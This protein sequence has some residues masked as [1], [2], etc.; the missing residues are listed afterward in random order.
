M[1]PTQERLFELFSYDPAT[2][3]FTRKVT[4]S[5]QPP[6]TIVG[7]PHGHRYLGVSVD[8]K[9]YYC[10]RLAW[11]YMTGSFPPHE[12]DHIN[13]NGEDNRW[14]NLRVADRQQNLMNRKHKLPRSGVKG[15]HRFWN[16]SAWYAQVGYKGKTYNLGTFR[17]LEEAAEAVKQ[18]RERL[19]GEFC[20]NDTL[21]SQ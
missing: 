3:S 1:A 2:G 16:D 19:H 7:H 13:G 5:N 12:I 15:V 17:C 10:H 14:E 4:V 6:G 11:L 21:Q 9:R 18:G 20:N 8:G